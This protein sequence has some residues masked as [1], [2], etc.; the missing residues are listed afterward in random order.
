MKNI[1]NGITLEDT[2]NTVVPNSVKLFM[3][4]PD[5][6]TSVSNDWEDENGLDIDLTN[7]TF[8]ARTFQF[9]CVTRGATMEELKANYFALFTLL[10]I[11]GQ[12]TWYND[13]V[14]MTIYVYFQ[15][16]TSMDNVYKDGN[17]GLAINHTLQFGETDPTLNL[18]NVYLVDDQNRFL[19]P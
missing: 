17:G 16:Q 5:R 8:E 12:Y 2:F 15:K 6:K 7:P 19:V 3:A 1:V 10:K 9:Q 4:L 13:F 14:N 18:P 11:S